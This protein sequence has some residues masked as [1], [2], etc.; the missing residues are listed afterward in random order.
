MGESYGGFRAAAMAE[1][2]P[3]DANVTVSGLVLIS[4]A[5]DLSILHPSERDV[6]AAGFYLADLCRHRRSAGGGAE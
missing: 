3:R 5:L 1:R 2:L 6:L 4:P